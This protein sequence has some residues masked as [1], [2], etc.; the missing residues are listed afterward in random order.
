VKSSVNRGA[1]EKRTGLPV[2]LDRHF[3]AGDQPG[4]YTT[5]LKMNNGNA[6]TMVVVAE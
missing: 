2:G 1:V 6:E 5:T 4:T 3:W